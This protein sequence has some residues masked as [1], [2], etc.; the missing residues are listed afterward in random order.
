[1]LALHRVHLAQLH[2]FLLLLHSSNGQKRL[3]LTVD[4]LQIYFKYKFIGYLKCSLQKISG[5]PLLAV[6]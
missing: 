2:T 3:S 4:I 5:F 6:G 1:M